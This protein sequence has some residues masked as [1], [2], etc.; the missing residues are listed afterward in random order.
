M[1]RGPVI[2]AVRDPPTCGLVGSG[3]D[4]STLRNRLRA[5]T[6]LDSAVPEPG[7]APGPPGLPAVLRAGPRPALAHHLPGVSTQKA[8]VRHILVAYSLIEPVTR[9]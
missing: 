2:F 1:S 5:R 3:R 9:A 7:R 4:I 8:N 6:K